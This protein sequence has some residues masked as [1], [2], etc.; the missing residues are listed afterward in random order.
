[1]GACKGSVWTQK[2]LRVCAG[3]CEVARVPAA[4]CVRV[5]ECVSV[6]KHRGVHTHVCILCLRLLFSHTSY[7]S[8]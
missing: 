8:P 4:V 1:M 7:T 5:C 3:M 6:R 2:L